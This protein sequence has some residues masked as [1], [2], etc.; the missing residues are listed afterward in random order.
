MLR[1]KKSPK[2]PAWPSILL[3]VVSLI[4]GQP[5]LAA[6]KCT[7][8]FTRRSL[9]VEKTLRELRL[10]PKKLE[11]T[12]APLHTV[13][14][15]AA[16]HRQKIEITVQIKPWEEDPIT[17]T[18][19]IISSVNDYAFTLKTANGQRVEFTAYDVVPSSIELRY[20]PLPTKAPTM[21]PD[22]HRPSKMAVANGVNHLVHGTYLKNLRGILSSGKLISRSNPESESWLL[23]SHGENAV[24]MMAVGKNIQGEPLE[25]EQ[26]PGFRPI[27]LVFDPQV[28]DTNAFHL[29]PSMPY[30]EYTSRSAHDFQKQKL[31]NLFW[32]LSNGFLTVNEV[33]FK[34]AVPLIE[35]QEIWVQEKHWAVVVNELKQMGYTPPG[36]IAIENFV[37]VKST[38]P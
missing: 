18:G 20:D 24:Y 25:S 2:D 36:G 33:V 5:S 31:H 14:K 16:E 19:R 28:L 30:G 22:L 37:V 6:P 4:G 1:S 12:M 13:L 17:Y 10:D 8:V 11:F 9:S 23:G 29:S 3:A 38:W 27:Y 34:T 32:S 15:E 21:T 35:L 26:F 7:K